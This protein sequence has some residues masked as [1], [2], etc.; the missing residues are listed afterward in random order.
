MSNA[1][2]GASLLRRYSQSYMAHKVIV[3]CKP[4]RGMSLFTV[5]RRWQKVAC[6]YFDVI[7]RH[8][9]HCRASA[10]LAPWSPTPVV[11]YAGD[12]GQHGLR[13]SMA[14]NAARYARWRRLRHTFPAGACCF[15]QTPAPSGECF[16]RSNGSSTH[17]SASPIRR[18]RFAAALQHARGA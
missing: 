18:Q 17:W 16:Y 8:F 2:D 9:Q 7:A 4:R 13:I 11:R 6:A 1:L 10:P 5:G 3:S 15:R 12:V 14:M